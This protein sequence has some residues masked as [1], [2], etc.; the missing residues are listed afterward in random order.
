MK[1][2]FKLFIT[3]FKIGAFTIGGGY[4]MLPLIQDEVVEKN[5]WLDPEEFMDILAVAEVTPGPVAV[6]TSTYVGYKLC[7]IKGAII[8]TL[9]TVLP[10]F[11][12]ILLI[13]K[14]FWQ[15]RENPIIDKMFLGIRPAVAALIFSA[16]YKLGKSTKLDIYK[17]IIA[18]ITVLA[19]V[20]FDISPIIVILVSAIGA[21][22]YFNHKEKNI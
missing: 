1:L 19:I 15:Y 4:A 10:S 16:V 2:L 6:N 9:G 12:I 11:T 21:I 18:A 20:V 17:L 5:N 22:F 3:F 14:F 7:G 13:V 8:S